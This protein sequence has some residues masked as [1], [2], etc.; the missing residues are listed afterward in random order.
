MSKSGQARV[1]TREQ[2]SHL[3]QVIREHRHPEK[4]TAIMQISFKLGLRA[5]E[6]ALLQVKEVA[7]LN[8]SGNDFK[9]LEIM[10]LPA[11][12]TKGADAMKR[13]KSH[14]Q[15]KTISFDI[16][17]FDK[18]VQQI[19]ALAKSGADI[20]PENFYPPVKQHK[21]KSR[22]LPMVDQDLR[23]ALAQ[24]LSLRLSKG[25]ILK[26]SSP[27]FVTQKGG[28]YSPNT[29]QEHMALMLRDWAGI[30]KASSHSGRRSLITD[31]IHKQKKSVKI[32]QKIAG[33]VNPSTTLIYEEPPE[34]VVED[35]LKN[36]G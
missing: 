20:N 13:S 3:F 22:D 8:P 1:P 19:E 33:H 14:Y 7:K 27:L 24:H 31:V 34:E 26:P 36:L 12:Y 32:A 5:Q 29:L 23:N 9:L 4:N 18:V 30:E 21:G 16:E 25:E 15:R 11:A 35:A 17:S 10:S 28:P 6:I 2:Q